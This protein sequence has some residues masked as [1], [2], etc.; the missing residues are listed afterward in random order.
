VQADIGILFEFD[1]GGEILIEVVDSIAGFMRY[2]QGRDCLRQLCAI[3][4][5]WHMKTDRLIAAKRG[6]GNL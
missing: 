5:Q 1:D 4:E 3:E 2:H 6:I